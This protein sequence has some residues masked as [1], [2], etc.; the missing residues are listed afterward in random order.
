[1]S[2][3]SL[4]VDPPVFTIYFAFRVQNRDQ[5]FK[6]KDSV[7]MR[8]LRGRRNSVNISMNSK[9]GEGVVIYSTDVQG[10]LDIFLA[11]N[12]L[13]IHFSTCDIPRL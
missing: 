11:L 4:I 12:E 13:N 9:P 7:E 8:Q 10:Q 1:M 3:M 2:D 6:V 5:A